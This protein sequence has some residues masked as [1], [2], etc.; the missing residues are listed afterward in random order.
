MKVES[1]DTTSVRTSSFI[2]SLVGCSIYVIIYNVTTRSNYWYCGENII[3]WERIKKNELGLSCESGYVDFLLAIIAILYVVFQMYGLITGAFIKAILVGGHVGFALV[4]VYLSALRKSRKKTNQVVEMVL[5][6]FSIIPIAYLM[7]NV[8]RFIRF[9][10]ADPST[11]ELIMSTMLIVAILIASKRVVGLPFTL[12]AIF[13]FIYVFFGDKIP[14][15]IGHPGFS[16]KRFVSHLYMSQEGIWGLVTTVSARVIAPFLILGAVFFNSGVTHILIEAAQKITQKMTGGIPKSAVI[17]SASFGMVSGSAAANVAVTGSMTIPAMIKTGY[18]PSFSGAVEAAASSGGQLMPPIMG[19]SAFLMAHFLGVPYLKIVAS[20]I[21]PA[22]VY[23]CGIFFGVHLYCSYIQRGLGIEPTEYDVSSD[24]WKILLTLT[25]KL[26][27]PIIL[28][29]YLMVKGHTISYAGIAAIVLVI[30]IFISENILTRKYY[31]NWHIIRMLKEGGENL[32]TI[33]ILTATAQIIISG[34]IISGIGL[35][36]SNIIIDLGGNHIFPSLI[37]SMVVCVV[38]GMGM[39]TVGAYVLAA[40]TV[41]P[42]L[43]KLGFEPICAHFFAFYF[44][45]MSAITPPVCAAVYVASSMARSPWFDTALWA[46]KLAIG[47]FITPYM[48]IYR[49]SLLLQTGTVAE[50]LYTFVVAVSGVIMLEGFVMG[51]FIGRNTIFHSLFLLFGAILMLLR[52]PYTDM[53]GFGLL[54][55]VIMSQLIRRR[56]EQMTI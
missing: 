27:L 15:Y 33:A 21:L 1:E 20:G 26:G 16:Y 31:K 24:L 34:V 36:L 38:L 25:Y 56:K 2:K 32:V 37:L 40:A 47:G 10:W 9:G 44:A 13:T 30:L 5:L 23:Y 28:L 35:K 17:A 29:L 11:L 41:A 8:N 18:K 42:A 46:C 7:L 48:F 54:F 4:I 55:I 53:T 51:Y 12:V 39:P 3:M 14:G 49:T 22:V 52:F 6:V 43:I 50:V 19:T 45:T